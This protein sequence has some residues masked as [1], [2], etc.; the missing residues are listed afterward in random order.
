MVALAS[1]LSV[2][3]L[4]AAM[5]LS[6]AEM[7]LHTRSKARAF[8]RIFMRSM[9][10]VVKL[11]HRWACKILFPA[12]L[13]LLLVLWNHLTIPNTLW[14]NLLGLVDSNFKVHRTT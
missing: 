2:M 13:I 11:D 6:L 3:T 4:F 5:G 7:Q 10:M 1:M 12:I 9:P 8:E 14:C